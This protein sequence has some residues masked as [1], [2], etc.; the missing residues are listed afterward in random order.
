MR[1]LTAL[2]CAALCLTVAAPAF[3]AQQ[4][5]IPC[6]SMPDC[7][8][9]CV[10]M[11]VLTR[12]FASTSAPVQLEFLDANR[13]VLATTFFDAL[14]GGQTVSNLDHPIE[15][16]AATEVRI[17]LPDAMSNISWLKLEAMCGLCGCDYC[18]VYKGCLCDWRPLAEEVVVVPVFVEPEPEPEVIVEIEREPEVIKVPGRG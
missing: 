2:L 18:P 6:P 4:A 3:A 9:T 5:Y 17:T 16:S 7:H 1:V 8:V 10:R 12:M 11:E 15:G 13:D 14:W